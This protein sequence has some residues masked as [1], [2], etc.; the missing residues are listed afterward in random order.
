MEH[1]D[2]L[3]KIRNPSG[4]QVWTMTQRIYAYIRSQYDLPAWMA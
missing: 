2:L 1:N 4:V 3:N